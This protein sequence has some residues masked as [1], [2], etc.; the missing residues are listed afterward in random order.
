[1]QVPEI[2]FGI[3]IF[4]TK[5]RAEL[6]TVAAGGL[7]LPE[8]RPC[9]SPSGVLVATAKPRRHP[10]LTGDESGLLRSTGSFLF[11]S[12]IAPAEIAVFRRKLQKQF[13]YAVALAAAKSA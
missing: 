12:P 2:F 13:M 8:P 6:N 11:R 9:Q 3:L 7:Q 10:D 5:H 4:E 1:M